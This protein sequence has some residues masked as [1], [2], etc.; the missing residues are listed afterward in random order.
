MLDLLAEGLRLGL[1]LLDGLDV[2][3]QTLGYAQVVH[4]LLRHLARPDDAGDGVRNVGCLWG[5]LHAWNSLKTL[6]GSAFE[7]LT[8]LLYLFDELGLEAL[9]LA[10]QLILD[11]VLG[12]QTL[13]PLELPKQLTRSSLPVLE[14]FL[15]QLLT[16]FF[17]HRLKDLLVDF[18]GP[19]P[20]ILSIL[21]CIE[22]VDL[23]EGVKGRVHLQSFLFFRS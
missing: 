18:D 20:L 11:R 6:S 22:R 17:L 21:I 7:F 9:S 23:S 4:E 2:T 8:V 1:E 15:S 16:D 12:Q 10:L 3:E 13:P 5:L 19:R 14:D